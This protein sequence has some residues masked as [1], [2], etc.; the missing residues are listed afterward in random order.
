M[1]YDKITNHTITITMPM[2]L[3][4][5]T[6]KFAETIF[7]YLNTTDATEYE[8]FMENDNPHLENIQVRISIRKAFCPIN[9]KVEP[10][11]PEGHIMVDLRVYFQ[12]C[13]ILSHGTRIGYKI[14]PLEGKLKIW[15]GEFSSTRPDLFEH[16]IKYLSD[17]LENII[18]DKKYGHLILTTD[19]K[20][21]M[22]YELQKMTPTVFKHLK[23]LQKR[24]EE[25]VCSVCLEETVTTTPCE[26]HLCFE[27]WEK[28]E[29][30]CCPLCRAGIEY[31]DIEDDYE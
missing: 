12:S 8:F 31:E 10:C 18:F 19:R 29:Q 14:Y 5:D 9:G 20:A 27:C 15:D 7:E 30:K 28:L 23:K 22:K 16:N 26:H 4:A 13:S 24:K 11:P 6:R 25:N 21:M 3:N 1:D 17:N 2:E